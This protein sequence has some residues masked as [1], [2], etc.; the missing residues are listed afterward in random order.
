MSA[1]ENLCD[2]IS[3]IALYDISK[4]KTQIKNPKTKNKK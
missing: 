2:I 4:N 3:T 1:A